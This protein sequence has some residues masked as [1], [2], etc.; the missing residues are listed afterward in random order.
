[1]QANVALTSG[2]FFPL[3]SENMNIMH[4]LKRSLPLSIIE[5]SPLNIIRAARDSPSRTDMSTDKRV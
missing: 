1:M 4:V 3:N 5:L 2:P